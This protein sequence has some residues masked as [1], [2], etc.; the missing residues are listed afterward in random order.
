MHMPI[1]T[2]KIQHS[3]MFAH[4]QNMTLLCISRICLQQ[5]SREMKEF[6]EVSFCTSLS[7][8][9]SLLMN[10]SGVCNRAQRKIDP[11]TSKLQRTTTKRLLTSFVAFPLQRQTRRRTMAKTVTVAGR[12]PRSISLVT[13]ANV[14]K[15]NR[16]VILMHKILQVRYFKCTKNGGF[17][18]KIVTFD[19]TLWNVY[20]LVGRKLHKFSI[21]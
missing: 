9:L 4:L 14:N 12:V 19:M 2:G 6:S 17:E 3:I 7:I 16:I 13:S 8:N 21:V 10:S 20:S 1:I 15:I 11:K 5:V 18:K